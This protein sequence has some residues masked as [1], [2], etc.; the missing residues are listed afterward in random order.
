MENANIFLEYFKV[1]IWPLTLLFVFW[2]GRKQFK[3]LIPLIQ[4][5]KYK[6]FEIE[7]SKNLDHV[8]K[9][10]EKVTQVEKVTLT[11][12]PELYNLIEDS[13]A[14]GV[15]KAW[16]SLEL[17]AKKKAKQLLPPD[18]TFQDP[19]SRPLV[20]LEWKGTFVPSTASAIHKLRMLQNQVYY[21]ED[22]AISTK[23]AI[24]YATLTKSIQKQI[25]SII[26]LPKVTDVTRL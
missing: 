9:D 20:Y 11:N 26:E 21:A 14:S 2:I 7:F 3:L 1:L 16:K 25:D 12:E 5:I 10:V 22:D 23:N 15:I 17:T 13:P 24:Q 6:E 4:K 8:R 19:L 18:E